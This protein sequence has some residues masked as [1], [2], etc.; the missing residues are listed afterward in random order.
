MSISADKVQ[1][2][3]ALKRVIARVYW[4]HKATIFA[5]DVRLDMKYTMLKEILRDA[6]FLLIRLPF[7]SLSLQN[8]IFTTKK[9]VYLD[10]FNKNTTKQLG[11]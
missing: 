1:D 6:I 3:L 11:F 7:K 8:I 2:N 5:G 4:Y 9:N 10:A